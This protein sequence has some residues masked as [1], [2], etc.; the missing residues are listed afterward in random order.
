MSFDQ[1]SL[2]CC[3]LFIGFCWL[4][5]AATAV[6]FVIGLIIY[7]PNAFWF[8]VYCLIMWGSVKLLKEKPCN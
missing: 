2:Y 5:L 3:M 6:F 4:L 1:L 8:Y 7:H